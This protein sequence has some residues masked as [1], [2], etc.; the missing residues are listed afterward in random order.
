MATKFFEGWDLDALAAGQVALAA[1]AGVASEF[2]R[3][4]VKWCAPAGLYH[5]KGVATSDI[6]IYP[7]NNPANSQGSLTQFGRLA[8]GA[9]GVPSLSTTAGCSYGAATAITRTMWAAEQG[10][11]LGLIRSE[12]GIGAEVWINFD[13]KMPSLP[14]SSMTG[15]QP[16]ASWGAFFKWGDVEVVLKNTTY[17][18]S[19]SVVFSI[20][21]N[22]V[23]VATLT[24]PSIPSNSS[25]SATTNWQ[26]ASLRVKLDAT[27]GSIE[28]AVNGIAQSVAYTGQNT[29]TTT[30]L[31]SAPYIYFGPPVFDNGTTSYVG[32]I[33]NYHI[34]D[35][36]YTTGRINFVLGTIATET[37]TTA[38]GG[39][40]SGTFTAAILNATDALAGRFT[41]PTGKVVSTPSAPSSLTGY[42]SEII[43]FQ[44][45]GK[46]CTSRNSVTARRLQLG[47]QVGGTDYM[48]TYS[49]STAL[50]FSSQLTPPELGATSTSVSDLIFEKTP[51][52]R[53]TSTEALSANL[54]IVFAS[55]A[56]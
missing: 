38:A 56:P 50:P 17:T 16:S 53:F 54:K 22:A 33:D 5:N 29:V 19:H 36:A 44:I 15:F 7:R 24:L 8:G 10:H 31:A 21:N 48:G 23:E 9:Y 37:S 4:G 20:R 6:N 3:S 26:Y 46:F 39:V 12:R 27:T 13:F 52:V 30:S 55:S 40:P 2:G 45:I 32:L 25:E 47:V 35:T 51:G 34:D 14:T 18:S 28:F 41:G 49:K 11:Q 43:G 42:L 1:T